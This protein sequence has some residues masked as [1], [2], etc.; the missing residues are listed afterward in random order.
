MNEPTIRFPVTCPTCGSERLTEFPVS[1]VADALLKGTSLCLL[2]TC[3]DQIWDAS[4]G[5]ME[6]IREYL[7]AV[8]PTT[9]STLLRK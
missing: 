2:T 1:V 8:W 9:Q 7:G 4:D 3:H 5:E 6:Q